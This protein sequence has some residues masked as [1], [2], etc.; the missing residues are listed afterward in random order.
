[1]RNLDYIKR[2]F[3]PTLL[4]DIGEIYSGRRPDWGMAPD[5]LFIR[6][7]ES[8]LAWPVDL[9]R[10]FLAEESARVRTFDA[11][12]QQWMSE[13]SWQFVRGTPELWGEA[14]DR[15][16]RTMVYVLANRLIFYQ[17][18]IQLPSA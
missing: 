8:H 1:M 16:A 15:A 17:S 9:T 10:A 18:R 12:L 13:Q 14:L 4:F 3:L 5:D 11:R 6:S 7:F 2:E